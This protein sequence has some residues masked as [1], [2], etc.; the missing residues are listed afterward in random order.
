MKYKADV[1][2]YPAILC[3]RDTGTNIGLFKYS[4]GDST[5]YFEP[6]DGTCLDTVELIALGKKL[7]DLK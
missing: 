5:Y 6:R 7:N 3:D 2:Q 1:P 4:K